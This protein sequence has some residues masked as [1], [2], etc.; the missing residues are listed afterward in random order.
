MPRLHS[1]GSTALVVFSGVFV[2]ASARAA[3]PSLSVPKTAGE[4]A[5]AVRVAPAGN[6]GD[7][8]SVLLY[9]SCAAEPCALDRANRLS[10]D[11]RFDATRAVLSRLETPA[12]TRLVWVK[13]PQTSGTRAYE[14]VLA[15]GHA[16]PLFAGETSAVDDPAATTDRLL[17]RDVAGKTLLV[18][19]STPPGGGLCGIGSAPGAIRAWDGRKWTSAAL[20]RLDADAKKRAVTLDARPAPTSATRRYL[21]PA[22]GSDES[23]G[24]AMVDFEPRTAWTETRSGDGAGEYAS[25]RVDK[26]L[27]LTAITFTLAPSNPAADFAAPRSFYV[28]LEGHAYHV[29]V[30]SKPGP[31]QLELAQ[32]IHTSCLSI[33]LDEASTGTPAPRSVGIA[34]LGVLAALDFQPETTLVRQLGDADAAKA[35]EALATLLGISSDLTATWR[36][37]YPA[38]SPARR[39]KVDETVAARGCTEAAPLAALALSDKDKEV[40]A[41]AARKLEQCRKESVPALI[42]ALDAAEPEGVREAGR[43]LALLAPSVAQ[44]ELPLRLGKEATRSALWPALGKAFRSADPAALRAA[45]ATANTPEA[46]LD[47]V[48]ALGERVA[49]AFP[50]ARVVIEEAVASTKLDVRFRA[51][52]PALRTHEASLVTKISSDAEPSV[53]HRALSIMTQ[54]EHAAAFDTPAQKA[55]ADANPR[56]RTAAAEYF[57][58][59]PEALGT[60]TP[61][62]FPAAA[63]PW[64]FVRL[65]ALRALGGAP[66]AVKQRAL[67]TV[68]ERLAD[69]SFDVR[70]GA[71][72]AMNGMPAA[73]VRDDI[74]ARLDDEDE[75]LPVR[76]QAARTLGTVCS[77]ADLDRL[78]TLAQAT[79]TPVAFELEREVGLAAI[80]ALGMIH[81][82]DLPKRLAPLRSPKAPVTLKAAAD[83]ALA[84]PP[85]CAIAK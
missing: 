53:R 54:R 43:L 60:V 19:S 31:L 66:L 58:A 36:K 15:P 20:G 32:P 7:K 45:L 62:L 28:L 4:P 57:R 16:E 79:L 22:G 48:L 17:T 37:V 64:P 73:W 13:I 2:A 68:K 55:L 11:L 74:M 24:R 29:Q 83:R 34:E 38:L 65:A 49:E 72:E 6:K 42:A 67:A 56:V 70:R 25:F 39:A 78:T 8:S 5:M 76:S 33:V 1:V 47:V 44:K 10:L 63:D 61:S 23:F 12:G 81:P 85:R 69:Q 77:V 50:E 9:A 21:V 3:D 82:A 40:R 84:A 18:H 26:A 80:E 27:G 46:K 71:L 75:A 51:V 14:V 59:H 52:E 30:P 35:D 41:R